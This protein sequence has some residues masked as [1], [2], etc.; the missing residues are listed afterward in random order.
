M[1]RFGINDLELVDLTWASSNLL[2]SWLRQI[3]RLRQA[4]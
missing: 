3:D 4:V 2:V 1:Q